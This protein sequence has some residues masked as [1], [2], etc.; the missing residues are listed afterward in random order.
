[1]LK[2][3]LIAVTGGEVFF[4]NL[5]LF[6][7]PYVKTVLDE[8]VCALLRFNINLVYIRSDWK[9]KKSIF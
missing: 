9:S 3:S 2:Q 7:H 5:F 6:D 1:L 8:F 4:I